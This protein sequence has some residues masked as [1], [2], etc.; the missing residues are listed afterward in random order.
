MKSYFIKWRSN[1]TG[2]KWEE[3][4]A[5]QGNPES[6]LEQLHDCHRA[7][8]YTLDDDLYVLNSDASGYEKRDWAEEQ[9]GIES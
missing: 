3:F 2:Q 9:K 4:G 8:A 5:M 7:S 1:D 6:I